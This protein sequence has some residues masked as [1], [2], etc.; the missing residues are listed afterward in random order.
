MLLERVQDGVPPAEVES[1]MM[2]AGGSCDEGRDSRT[3][4]ADVFVER[5][6]V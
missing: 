3:T 6:N 5:G 1:A 2:R 4:S